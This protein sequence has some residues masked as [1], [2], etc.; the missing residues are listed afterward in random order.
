[1][2][3]SVVDKPLS[4]VSSAFSRYR[5]VVG[6]QME[7]F[8]KRNHMILVWS[9]AV[10]VCI[11][12][13]RIM[14]GIASNFD[15]LSEGTAKYGFLALALTIVAFAGMCFRTW[16]AI[17]PDKVYRL[18]MSKLNA[19][20]GILEVMGAP[21]TGTDLRAYVTS[22]GQPKLK[23][24]KLK[25]GGKRCFLLFPVRGSERKGLVSVE[26]KKKKGQYAMKLLA[27]DIPMASGPDQRLYVFGDEQEYRVG[28]GLISELK[29]PI[30][31][32]MSA[33]KE[34]EDLD[35]KEDE[36]DEIRE[37]EEA[38]RRQQEEKQRALEQAK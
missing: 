6:L 2:G 24:F 29:D 33:E 32:A 22:G 28:G 15:G 9:G 20:A 17:N 19:S 14:F 30:A 4:A 16:F 7:A 23:N 35:E 10:V 27:V 8:W 12:L 11:V 37:R 34:F 36:E 13:W 38:E 1:M 25:F 26:V 3:K 21:L 5:E 31:K 18:A